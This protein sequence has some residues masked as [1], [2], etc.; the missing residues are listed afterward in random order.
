MSDVLLPYEDFGRLRLATLVHDLGWPEVEIADLQNWQYLGRRWI[1][2]GIGAFTDFLRPEEQPDRLG[3][4]TLELEQLPEAFQ[5]R[6]LA[7]LR[8]PIA[9]G[10][11]LSM[12]SAALSRRTYRVHRF[13]TD[14]ITLEFLVRDRSP[15][16][17]GC[18]VLHTGGLCYL[19]ITAHDLISRDT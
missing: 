16:L 2:E 18:T 1:G 11:D 17:V 15:Y 7:K 3:A 8:L 19:T 10:M 9:R 13:V 14:R 6:L 12:L 4:I 5:K